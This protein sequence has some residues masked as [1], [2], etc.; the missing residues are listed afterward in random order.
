MWTRG[1]SRSFIEN[2]PLPGVVKSAAR[3]LARKV[4]SLGVVCTILRT[5]FRDCI[6]DPCCSYISYVRSHYT[7]SQCEKV[8]CA[9]SMRKR[10]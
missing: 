6:A 4:A 1:K 3:S 10:G 5:Y 9:L 8:S 7:V 2:T